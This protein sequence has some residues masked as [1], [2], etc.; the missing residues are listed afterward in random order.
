M[1]LF[2]QSKQFILRFLLIVLIL[3]SLSSLA[4]A[5]TEA[6]AESDGWWLPHTGS[7]SGHWDLGVGAHWWN[8]HFKLRNLQLRTNM[9]L[10]PGLRLNS[11]LRSNEKFDSI[12]G[13]DPKFDEVYLEAYAFHNSDLGKLSMS[14]KNGKMRYLRFPEPDIISYFDHVPGTEDLR[15]EDAETGYNGQLLILDF[16]SKLGLGYH[17]TGINWDYGDRD[18]AI[19]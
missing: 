18:G 1:I 12:E 14:L 7:F 3:I 4:L 16:N 5:A 8:D 10:A 6:V 19:G 13:F 9:D 17:L 2:M 15:F 11:I